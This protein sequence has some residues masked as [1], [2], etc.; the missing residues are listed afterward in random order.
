MHKPTRPIRSIL[1][2]AF[3]AYMLA[4]CRRAAPTSLIEAL[5]TIPNPNRIETIACPFVTEAGGATV[6][7]GKLAVP[8]DYKNPQGAQIHLLVAIAHSTGDN[9]AKDPVIVLYADPGMSYAEAA[10][11]TVYD[12]LWAEI[13]KERDLVFYDMR[14]VGYSE[15]DTACPDVAPAQYGN[16]GGIMSRDER[17]KAYSEVMLAC[18]DKLVQSG[19]RLENYTTAQHVADL[20]AVRTALEAQKVNLLAL[21]YGSYLSMRLMQ[22]YPDRIRS[23]LLSSPYNAQILVY[24]TA[25]RLQRVLT[26]VF[27]SCK[28]SE[29][30][31][32]SY[33]SLEEDFYA[34]VEKLNRAP[35]E[36]SISGYILNS[37]EFPVI[38][39]GDT[40]LD[41]AFD[42]ASRPTIASLPGLVH[43]I[44]ID[45]TYH[46]I[47]RIQDLLGYLG[48][49]NPGMSQ[50]VYCQAYLEEK[51]KPRPNGQAH[52]VLREWQVFGQQTDELI[53]SS[54]FT[55][56]T[57]LS[58][59]P[60]LSS[61]VPA[62]VLSGDWNSYVPP[63]WVKENVKSFTGVKL[64]EFPN[65]GWLFWTGDCIT[66]LATAF[67]NDPAAQLNTSC[68]KETPAVIFDLP[69]K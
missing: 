12:P 43:N 18:R 1:L 21:G 4:A 67:L 13:L 45:R 32:A 10:R 25:A 50:T 37:K 17:V 22:D 44:N 47:P 30:C 31:N 7:C 62:L 3:L 28:A 35:A 57:E 29:S 15:P 48:Y 64:V 39:T 60:G 54:W 63:D 8:E 19:I 42:M 68:A 26:L 49:Q 36:I 41:M 58:G 24:D 2:I 69:M 53:C 34:T 52:K 38:V 11:Y 9:P 5:P 59:N 6:T 20:N 23:A 46:L 27:E 33:P 51:A 65:S 66:Q 40:F 16:L 14:G 61:S 56:K 55:S